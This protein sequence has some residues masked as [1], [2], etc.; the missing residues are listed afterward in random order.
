MTR[1]HL[2]KSDSY[3]KSLEP[4]TEEI[5]EFRGHCQISR[6]KRE[7]SRKKRQEKN[8]KVHFREEVSWSDSM[9]L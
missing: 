1:C 7:I 4:K 6:G 8:K 3:T 5:G 9:A 2:L